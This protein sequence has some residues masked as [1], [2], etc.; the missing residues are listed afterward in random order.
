MNTLFIEVV[1]HDGSVTE[2]PMTRKLLYLLRQ[3]GQQTEQQL[4]ENLQA[5]GAF[6]AVEY[7]AFLD[8]YQNRN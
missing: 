1:H 6:D 2:E 7:H 8:T 4:R 3:H 5:I